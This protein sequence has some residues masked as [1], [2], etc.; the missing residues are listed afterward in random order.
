MIEFVTKLGIWFQGFLKP[1][2]ALIKVPGVGPFLALVIILVGITVILLV[3]YKYRF[4]FKEL[5]AAIQALG[6]F[7]NEEEFC[8]N[9]ATIDQYFSSRNHL[10]GCW[11]EFTE[12]IINP[13]VSKPGGENP[14]I[15]NTSRPSEFFDSYSAGFTTPVLAIWPNIFVGIGLFLTFA[16]LIAAL[17]TAVDGMSGNTSEMQ[18]TLEALLLTTSAKFYTSLMALGI[19]IILTLLF[20]IVNTKRD[21]LFK[22]LT[23]KIERGM[24]FV[25]IEEISFSQLTE[26]REQK[27]QLQ[28]FN[29]DLA[30]KLGEHIQSAVST[31]MTPVV[32]QLSE[33]SGNL[34]Q[35]N[36]EAMKEIGDT[37]AKNVQGAA[38]ESLGHLSDRLDTLTTVLGDMASNLSNSTGQFE[39]DIA[40]A[41]DS[42]KTGM[43][44]LAQDLQNNASQTSDILSE[45]LETL[46]ESLS[47]AANNIKSNLEEGA[48]QV[49]SELEAAISKLTIATDQSA[50]KMGSAVDGIKD[51]VT[52]I[53]TTMENSSNAA[54]QVAKEKMEEA[55]EK[56][57]AEFSAA[58]TSMSNALKDALT[59]LSSNMKGF[60]ES[61]TRTTSSIETMN[62]GLEKTSSTVVKTNQ[63]LE[64]SVNALREASSNVSGVIQPALTAVQNIQSAVRQMDEKVS[65]SANQMGS[66]VSQLEE[67]MKTSGQMWETHSLKFEGVNENLGNVFIKVNS[68]IEDSLKRMA[69]FV[70][71]VDSTFRTAT[72][73]LQEAVEE[74]ADE[75]KSGR[76]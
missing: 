6:K 28:Q 32:E 43:V 58:G 56:A 23:D 33:M 19:S 54:G 30:M 70:E 27:L 75:R 40:G 5:K 73:A 2:L 17:T 55:G 63:G 37:I 21:N 61:L 25:S 36:I 64:T 20:R 3:L 50:E 65:S 60:E 62:I 45:K 53:S 51:A 22:L 66:A 7:E 1:L 14:I 47:A 12:T 18:K 26:L 11:V 29:T 4:F 39:S 44:S 34:G 16:G 72:A 8:K 52:A 35:N 9:Y 76:T 48:S 13:N 24:L 49:S 57:A 59:D 15:R 67:Q 31:A 38:G 10:G 68:Q 74:L 69:S 41:L 71:D 42:M 46:A